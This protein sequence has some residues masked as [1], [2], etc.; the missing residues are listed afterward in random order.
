M[1]IETLGLTENR[2]SEGV[3]NQKKKQKATTASTHLNFN[4]SRKHT[5]KQQEKNEVVS[6]NTLLHMTQ[7]HNI[8]MSM[9]HIHYDGLMVK[10]VMQT[11]RQT[12][13]AMRQSASFEHLMG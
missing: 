2:V 1:E 7:T 8:L 10:I 3:G 12:C 11:M 9:S 4:K 13:R 5:K 6:M